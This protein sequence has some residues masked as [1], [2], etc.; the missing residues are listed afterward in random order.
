[1]TVA[2]KWLRWFEIAL[3]LSGVLLLGGVFAATV[4]RWNYQSRQ[5]RALHRLALAVESNPRTTLHKPLHVADPRQPAPLAGA[6]PMLANARSVDPLN[7]GIIEIPRVGVNAVV[8]EGEDD[9]TLDIAVGHIPG[10]AHPGEPGNMALAGHRDTFFRG[11]RNIR[12]NDQVRF[13]SP[14]HTYQYRVIEMTVV[15]PDEISVLDS[16]GSEELTLVTCHP[17][18]YIGNAPNRFIVRA[19]RVK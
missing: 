15:S 18:Q 17:F 2:A 14:S 16:R 12:L 9:A 7:M 8:R 5:E 3:T 1:M 11:L 10:T 13:V 19:A 4:H 6:I